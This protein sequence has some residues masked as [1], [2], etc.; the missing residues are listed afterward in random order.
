MFSLRGSL[1]LLAA[2]LLG[3]ALQISNGTLNPA[4]ARAYS[5][6]RKQLGLPNMAKDYTLQQAWD[7]F[8]FL[9]GLPKD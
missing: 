6:Y 2:S 7:A 1:V 4:G 5:A 3:Y 9:E 8:D